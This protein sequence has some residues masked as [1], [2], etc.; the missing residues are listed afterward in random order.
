MRHLRK[1]L[2]FPLFPHVSPGLMVVGQR[3]GLLVPSGCSWICRLSSQDLCSQASWFGSGQVTPSRAE[4]E[5]QV[6]GDGTSM[7]P[8]VSRA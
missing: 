5:G 8:W 6:G 2:H 4:M 1:N 3:E 7:S